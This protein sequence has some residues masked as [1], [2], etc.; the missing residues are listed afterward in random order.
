VTAVRGGIGTFSVDPEFAAIEGLAPGC[1][2]TMRFGT[3]LSEIE[4][5]DVTGGGDGFILVDE[6]TGREL[7]IPPAELSR[8]KR[9]VMANIR[10]AILD[11]GPDGYVDLAS[12]T[13][14]VVEKK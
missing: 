8:K 11:A 6:T 5:T 7:S 9:R 1:K 12:H 10:K 14:I 13:L 2:V 3:W 4:D